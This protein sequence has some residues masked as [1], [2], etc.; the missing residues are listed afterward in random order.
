MFGRQG[1]IGAPGGSSQLPT[2]TAGQFGLAQ[3]T[4]A[5]PANAFSG[6]QSLGTV[7]E[8]IDHLGLDLVYN[9]SGRAIAISLQSNGETIV[10]RLIVHSVGPGA[11]L[12]V[13]FPIRIPAG[14]LQIS[15]ASN[16]AGNLT[17][18]PTGARFS[19]P[20]IASSVV[21]LTAV[22]LATLLNT[23]QSLAMSSAAGAWTS[24]GGPLGS[25]A[26][27]IILSAQTGGDFDRAPTGP[28]VLQ[29]SLDGANVLGSTVAWQSVSGFSIACRL[30]EHDIPAG[31]QI[32]ARAWPSSLTPPDNISLSISLV[33]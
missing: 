3:A 1:T 18:A 9:T 25:D 10:D 31:A 27:A 17:V 24:I 11:C 28:A 16:V 7:A 6:W 13:P 2:V 12:P 22:N 15:A 19:V 23:G 21:P 20:R 4:F 5:V 8:P 33:R 32:R 29:I 26:K 30:F 14:P